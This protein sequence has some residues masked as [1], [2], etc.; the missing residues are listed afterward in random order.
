MLQI[1]ETLTHE[2]MFR[3]EQLDLFSQITGDFNPIHTKEYYE[4]HPEQGGVIVQGMLAASKFGMVF[5][6]EFPG[7][8]TINMERSFTFMRPVFTDRPYTMNLKLLSVDTD[9]HTATLKLS[10]K[11]ENGKICISGR[12]VVKNNKAIVIENYP[13]KD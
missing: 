12:T 8:G 6:T 7:P 1:N 9:N 13:N 3:Q 4:Q 11:D 2:I 5:G 10:V